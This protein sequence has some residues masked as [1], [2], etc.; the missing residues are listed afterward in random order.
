M[1]EATPSAISAFPQ[2]DVR[3]SL[4]S[5]RLK[6][7]P[8]TAGLFLCSNDNKPGSLAMWRGAVGTARNNEA[9]IVRGL[10]LNLVDRMC[11][12]TRATRRVFQG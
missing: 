7:E 1:L 8:E 5:L 4:R 9:V 2:D 11:G 10:T 12:L 3:S 6:P